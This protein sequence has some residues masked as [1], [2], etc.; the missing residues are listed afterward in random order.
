M[1]AAQASQMQAGSGGAPPA[2]G[3]PADAVATLWKT[4][5][6][7]ALASLTRAPAP[8]SPAQP[9]H[10]TASSSA[11]TPGTQP[12]IRPPFPTSGTE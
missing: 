8:P 3:S 7:S 1:Q 11:S 9:E 10:S 4:Y 6:S 12:Y 5:G 2:R